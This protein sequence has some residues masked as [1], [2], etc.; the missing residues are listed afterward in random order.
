[1][2]ARVH[3]GVQVRIA[4]SIVIAMTIDSKQNPASVDLTLGALTFS[5]TGPPD[6]LGAQLDRVI[7]AATEMLDAGLVTVQEEPESSLVASEPSMASEEFRGSLSSHI[8]EKNGESNQVQRFLAT[9]D[10]LRRRGDQTLTTSKVSAAL[11][12]GHQKRLSNAS[13]ALNKNVGKGFCEKTSDGFFITP[14]G[15]SAL[16]YE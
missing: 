3:K 15:L 8:R 4:L 11:K 9:A 6:W 5:A 2:G 14:D 1:M 10:W 12:E 16:G 7:A 13:D